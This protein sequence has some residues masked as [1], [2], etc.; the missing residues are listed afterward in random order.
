MSRV[1]FWIVRAVDLC[2]YWLQ[3]L[4]SD[5]AAAS[6]SI[7]LDS[8]ATDKLIFDIGL[9]YGGD[10]RYYLQHGYRVVAVDS[11]ASMLEYVAREIS[12]GKLTT[13]HASIDDNSITTCGGLVE[14]FG[15]PHYLKAD[16]EGFDLTCISSLRKGS[17]PLF[18]SV[19]LV[20]ADT[21]EAC[22]RMQSDIVHTLHGLGY[23]SFKIVRQ[24]VY[25]FLGR[26]PHD[27]NGDSSGPFGHE[28]IDFQLGKTWR[29]HLS[30]LFWLQ[31]HNMFFHRENH[32][33]NE[34]YD[35]HA[36]R[37]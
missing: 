1:Y 9:N 19:E 25:N 28:A 2:N 17:L 32:L 36:F 4:Y 3:E 15:V 30:V 27:L 11:D 22:C 37:G 21:V 34:W 31:N 5:F 24:H 8:N 33:H 23:T 14:R 16:I 13:I 26:V 18:V 12:N 6:Q 10:T 35:L 29:P 7:S 20:T